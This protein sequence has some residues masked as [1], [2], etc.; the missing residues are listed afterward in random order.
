[1]LA[2]L[3]YP[4]RP[5]TRRDLPLKMFA[6]YGVGAVL[7]GFVGVLLVLA[8]MTPSDPPRAVATES[9]PAAPGLPRRLPEPVIVRPGRRPSRPFHRLDRQD[10]PSRRPP[11]RKRLLLERLPRPADDAPRDLASRP[12]PPAA[13]PLVPAAGR[14][15]AGPTPAPPKES[16]SPDRCRPVGPS[17]ATAVGP[18]APPTPAT[19]PPAPRLEP[20][21]PAAPQ[22]DH[23]GLA[24]YYQRIGNFDSA[25]AEYRILL[26]QNDASAEVHNNLGLLYQDRGEIDEA[27]R[28][29]QRAIAIAPKHMKAHNNLGVAQL[30]LG[31]LDASAAEF[32]VA[33]AEDPRYVEALVN[34]AL[35]QKAAGRTAEARELLQQRCRSISGTPG[36]TTTWRSWPTRA[37][38]PPRRSSTIVRSAIGQRDPRR[39]GCAVRARLT[40]LGG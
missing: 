34:L 9:A 10:P 2:T 37:A 7:F 31:R 27:V 14:P 22:T 21:G 26:E 29:F 8:V 1:M 3:G 5:P 39:A 25:L 40:A 13:P 33:L 18:L 15:A 6:I 12:M 24:L 32:R 16:A 20:P 19:E 35:V 36:H 11:A 28:Q 23:F 17:H 4:Q 30:R 38:I